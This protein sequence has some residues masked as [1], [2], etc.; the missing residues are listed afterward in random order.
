MSSP[1]DNVIMDNHLTC[2]IKSRTLF[3]IA[4]YQATYSE[5]E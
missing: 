1:Y 5:E 4:G 2:P 3:V